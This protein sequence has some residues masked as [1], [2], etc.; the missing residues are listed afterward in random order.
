[1][2]RYGFE[3]Y[4]GKQDGSRAIHLESQ[5][6]ILQNGAVVVKGNVNKFD[7][8]GAGKV[9]QISGAIMLND[10]MAPGEYALEIAVRDTVSRQER[11]QLFAFQIN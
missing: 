2:L 9:P 7:S 5:A 3:V 8:D 11:R 10:K 4:N 1:V 6:N